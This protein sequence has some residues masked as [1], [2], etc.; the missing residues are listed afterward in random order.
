MIRGTTPTYI[1]NIQ[2]ELF[3]SAQRNRP[4]SLPVTSNRVFPSLARVVPQW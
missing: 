3:P 2:E 1:I 4:R